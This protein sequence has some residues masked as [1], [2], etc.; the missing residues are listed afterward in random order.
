M[1]INIKGHTSVMENAQKSSTSGSARRF[2]YR[3]TNKAIRAENK[4][5]CRSNALYIN[6]K[7]L[8]GSFE[9]DTAK[10]CGWYWS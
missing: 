6:D 2:V 9:I 4:R 1:K 8:L 5:V 7:D 3:Q 10:F